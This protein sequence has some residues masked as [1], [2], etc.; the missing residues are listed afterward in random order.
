[1]K[2]TQNLPK[3]GDFK[4]QLELTEDLDNLNGDYSFTFNDLYKITLWKVS[5]FP[6]I[7]PKA[8]DALNNLAN[9]AALNAA[10]DAA[11]VALTELLECK[12]VRLAMAS[13][14]LR[15]RNPKVFQKNADIYNMQN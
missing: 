14:Y 15:F 4:Y 1:M 3:I 12:G 13:T 6:I 5:R 7:K 8:L 9:Y 2:K 10:K 11:R